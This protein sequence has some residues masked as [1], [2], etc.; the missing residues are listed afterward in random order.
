[1][2]VQLTLS[3]TLSSEGSRQKASQDGPLTALL[4]TQTQA[5]KNLHVICTGDQRLFLSR[6]CPL[7]RPLL[8]KL[9]IMSASNRTCYLSLS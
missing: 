1:M 5:P 2:A 8:T 3:G 6:A 4:A 7:Q 9:S